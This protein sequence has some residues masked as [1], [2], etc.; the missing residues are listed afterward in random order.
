M[1]YKQQKTKKKMDNKK[2]INQT[3]D[4]GVGIYYEQN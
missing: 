3:D 1:S 2:S 4:V